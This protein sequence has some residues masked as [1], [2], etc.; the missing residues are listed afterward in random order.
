M[1]NIY[2]LSLLMLLLLQTFITNVFAG[3]RTKEEM[4]MAALNTLSIKNKTRGVVTKTSDLKEY[5]TKEKLSVFGCE[6]LGFAVVTSD[7]S[8]EEVIGYSVTNFS[9]EMPC[10]FK[11]WLEAANEVMENAKGQIPSRSHSRGVTQKSSVG[12]LITTKWGQNKPYNNK[13]ILTI[14][15]KDYSL[16][17]GC[18]A[19]AMAQV[20]NYYKYPKKGK[21]ENSY[22]KRYQYNSSIIEHKFYSKFENSYYDWNNMLDDY[23]G[24]WYSNTE[25]QYTNAVSLL[26]SDCGIAVN[27]NYNTGSSGASSYNVPIGL[28]K[29]FSYTFWDETNTKYNRNDYSNN[30]WM[31][32]I[33]SALNN[34]HPILYCGSGTGG[35]MFVIHGYDSNGKVYVNWGWDGRYDGY[36]MIDMLTPGTHNYNY[37]QEMIIPIPEGDVVETFYTLSYIVDEKVYKEYKLKYG[38]TITPEPAPAKEGYTFSGWSSIPEKMPAKDV[39]IV[40][41]FS[42]GTYK[43]IYMIDGKGYKTVNYNFGTTITPEAT[44]TKEGYS[45]SGWSEIPKTMPAKDVTVT[46][47]FTVNKYKLTYEVDGNVY[48]TYEIEYGAKIT[49]EVEPT[50]E[51][52]IFSG[53]SKIPSTMPD[54]NVT[55]I[56]TFSKDNDEDIIIFGVIK[57]NGILYKIVDDYVLVARQD[58][59]LSGKIVI[60]ASISC[61]NKDYPVKGFVDPTN[62]TAWSSNTVTTEGGAFQDCQIT[63]VIIPSS[64][65]KIPAGAFCGCTKLKS[66]TLPNN[67]ESIG[68]AC[69]AGCTSLEVLSIPDGVKEFGSDSRY[70]FISYTFG[71]C[72][73]LKQ[74]NIPSSITILYEGC[75][76]DAGLES[77]IIPKTIVSLKDNS[78]SLP[79]LRIVKTE[80]KDPTK[81]SYSLISFA[82]VSNADLYVPKGS[83]NVYRE[84]EPWSNFRSITEFGEEGEEINPTQINITYDGIKYILKDGMATIGRQDKSLS[85]NIT[86]PAI[87]TYKN[88]NYQVTGMVEPTNITCYSDNTIVCEG[89]AFQGSS[90]ESI[91]IPYTINTISAGAFQDCKQLK[92]VVLPETIKKLSA[93]CFAGCS[94][95]EDI[96]I[97]EGLTDLA[98]NTRYGYMS[99]VFGGCKKIKSFIIPSG[100]SVLASGCFLNSGIETVSIPAGCTQMDEDCL[101]AP[102]LHQ[103]TMYVR[104]LYELSYTESCF[105]SVS[106]AILRVPIGSKQV[107]QEYYPWMNFALIEEFD[108][109]NGL[110]VPP[111]ITTQ[112]NNIRYILSGNNATVGRQNKDLSGDVII[113][114]TVSYDGK[115]YTVNGMIEPTNLIAWSSNTVSTEN[116]AFQ[117]CPI[118]S[119]TL[120]STIKVISAGAFYDCHE[121]VEI[122]MAEGVTQLGA[123]CFANCTKLVEIQIPESVKEFGS[124]TRY[125]DKSYILGNCTSLKKVNIPTSVNIFSEGCFKGCGLETFIIPENIKTLEQDCFSMDKLKAIKITHR[126][127]D[128][129]NYTE[130]IFTNVSNVSLYVPDGTAKL[131][132]MFYPWKDFNEIVEYKDQ[133]DEFLFNAYRVSYII[134]DYS[135]NSK[136]SS[137]ASNHENVYMN[138]YCAS[139]IKLENVDSPTKEGY[140][141]SGWSG[142]PGTMPAHDVIVT[143]YFTAII[144]KILGDANNDGRVNVTDI[145][146]INNYRKGMAPAG[147]NAKAADLN[148]DS[149]VD[150]TDIS[151]L[152]KMIW[153][154]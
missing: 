38:E 22:I 103:V 29:Y 108:D 59:D 42:K 20:M 154:K 51:G 7:D 150:D 46:G 147:F 4:R 114:S 54:H 57:D 63:S 24:Y 93:A 32:L 132:K 30:D 96:N 87:I 104:D 94:N 123:A 151:I 33:Y 36:Y 45:F 113:P 47:S 110:F 75:F 118:T 71:N 56:G 58:K 50:K 28:K 48:K 88:I 126:N 144:G 15:G 72:Q 131:Y 91:S 119:I 37:N 137:S 134:S 74:I 148:N 89:G 18:V 61:E 8:F 14:E 27:M 69:F 98:S 152:V 10:G 31:N 40:G 52:C 80:I 77:V 97:P 44:P 26:M 60:P 143:G 124:Y 101:D 92:K 145:V 106:N 111:K 67:L 39:T 100:V 116:G 82:S 49:P 6:D 133:K 122:N 120:P 5:L 83:L 70:G 90:I 141:F 85:G 135:S 99:Y 34:N 21:G 153:G 146:A 68:A 142:I 140:T 62:I 86:I 129:I 127:L 73:N 43:L 2:F 121:L 53:W 128:N 76:K 109:G 25:N 115:R 55:I 125:G 64:I 84:Y 11:W 112:I 149:K 16:V 13:C 17:T 130:S 117:S 35:H 95:L 105:G 65:T 102:N 12:P 79:N 81:I 107:Y 3:E 138:N 9:G 78:L 41:S 19:T 136:S 66:V 1:K 23:S 139:G